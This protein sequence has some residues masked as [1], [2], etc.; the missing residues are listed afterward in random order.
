MNVER[1]TTD[2]EQKGG[3]ARVAVFL[4]FVPLA[5][6]EDF[7]DAAFSAMGTEQPQWALLAT[8]VVLLGLILL[9]RQKLVDSN[10]RGLLGWWAGGAGLTLALDAAVTWNWVL[11][12]TVPG[13]LTAS[14]LYVVSGYP[15]RRDRRGEPVADAD[16]RRP[17]QG[18]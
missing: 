6:S 10:D 12:D 3:A 14:L 9:L 7:L 2:Q 8:D 17:G 16:P 1:G 5:F 18:P 15:L 4:A 11:H 13:D